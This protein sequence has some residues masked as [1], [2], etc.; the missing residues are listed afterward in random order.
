MRLTVLVFAAILSAGRAGAQSAEPEPFHLPVSIERIRLAL[1]HPPVL[2]IRTQDE[3]PT[4]RIQILEKQR[5]DELLATLDFKTTRASAG[6][7]YWDEMQ[8]VTWPSVDNPL[9]QP[10]GAFSGGQI[11]TLAVENVVGK[12]GVG[13]LMNAIGNASKNRAQTAA[14]EEVLQA[15]QDYC[16]AQPSGGA[17]IQICTTADAVR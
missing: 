8:R 6:G 9:L 7:V 14:R 5:I 13:K 2:S 17:G 10:Y 3:R 1:E 4:F 16:A 15:I 11:I 12:L